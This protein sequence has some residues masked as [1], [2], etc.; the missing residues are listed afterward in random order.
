MADWKA[1]SGQRWTAPVGG[2]VGKI[3]RI[4]MLPV[5]TRLSAYYNLVTPEDGPE[6]ADSG[7]AAVHVR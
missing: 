3:F 6:L 5:N 2:S 1:E 7:A 4:G